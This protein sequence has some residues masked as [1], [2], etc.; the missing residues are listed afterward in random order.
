M[1][2]PLEI[3]ENAEIGS[4][5]LAEKNFAGKCKA[6]LT[7]KNT[8]HLHDE[9]LADIRESNILNYFCPYIHILRFLRVIFGFSI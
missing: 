9:R 6:I 3:A 4:D 2:L 8:V 7:A 1:I 5:L